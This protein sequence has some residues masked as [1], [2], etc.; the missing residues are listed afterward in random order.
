MNEAR[1]T[2]MRLWS[3]FSAWYRRAGRGMQIGVAVGALIVVCACCSVGISALGKGGAS[4]APTTGIAAHQA[5]ATGSK[6]PQPVAT[7]SPVA[8]LDKEVDNSGM[9]A[10]RS[11]DVQIDTTNQQINVYIVPIRLDD[12]ETWKAAALDVLRATWTGAYPIPAAWT[13]SLRFY[14]APV[15]TGKQVGFAYASGATAH[16]IAWS[17]VTP[18]QA[19]TQYDNAHLD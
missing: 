11:G 9:L 10:T 12:Q 18:D 16:Q 5:T 19:W 14:D 4:S 2:A 7:L 17:S 13:V 3:Q 6:A 8:Q 1:A 15:G